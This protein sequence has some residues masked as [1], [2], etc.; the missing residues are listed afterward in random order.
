MFCVGSLDIK[1]TFMKRENA[2]KVET[3]QESYVHSTDP[4]IIAIAK[5]R[6]RKILIKKAETP[7]LS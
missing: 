2:N 6:K 3:D 5:Y 1:W 4:F 7:K